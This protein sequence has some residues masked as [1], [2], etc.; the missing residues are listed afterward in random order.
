MKYCTSYDGSLGRANISTLLAFPL[1]L[2]IGKRVEQRHA[3][4][5]IRNVTE[6]FSEETINYR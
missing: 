4:E 6:L 1:I 5:Y 3:H 2:F